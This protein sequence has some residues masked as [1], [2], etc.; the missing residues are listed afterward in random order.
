[1]TDTSGFRYAIEDAPFLLEQRRGEN[2]GSSPERRLRALTVA[3]IAQLERQGNVC[4]DWSR[5]LVALDFDPAPVVYNCFLDDVVL[6][7]F[8]RSAEQR[9]EIPPGVFGSTLRDVVVEDNASIHRCPL[10]SGY[11][12]ATGAVVFDSTLTFDGPSTQGNGTEIAAGIESGGREIALLADLDLPWAT[13]IL[14]NPADSALREAYERYTAAYLAACNR[15]SGY[16]GRGAVVRHCTRIENSWIG[17][18]AQLRGVQLLRESSVHCSAE[19]P[20]VLGDGVIVEYSIVQHGARVESGAAVQ[21]ALIMEYAAVEHHAKVDQSIIGPNSSIGEGEVNASLIGPFVGAHH[22]SLLIAACWPEGRGTIGYG[23]NVGSN[24]TSR[25]P[26]QELWPGEGMFFGLS[27][28]IKMPANFRDAPY[29]VIAAGVTTLPQRLRFPF[30]LI[31]E[32]GEQLSGVSPAFN[33]L[34]PAWGLSSNL[35]GLLRNETKFRSRDRARR[36]RF[37]FS[38]FRDD[39]LRLMEDSVR[40]LEAVPEVRDYYLPGDLDGIGKNYVLESDRK[41]AVETYRFFLRYTDALARMD[42]LH[43]RLVAEN[44]TPTA[45]DSA[46]AE[47]L[48]E[49]ARMIEAV[50]AG[51]VGSRAKDFERGVRIIDDYAATHPA[52]D[53]DALIRDSAAWV[54]ET[55]DRIATLQQRIGVIP[56][57]DVPGDPDTSG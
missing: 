1:M 42:D 51:V 50:H 26:D 2:Q 46:A 10:V 28:A 7:V 38:V 21:Q 25:A 48:G 55:Q 35:Y 16:V 15:N 31:L 52:L 49:L 32:A 37:D 9:C 34:I 30:S 43:R 44:G 57:S 39:I 17:D 36:H 12:I 4:T 13:R 56:G 33:R 19:E 27:C 5:V 24:H 53:N 47:T 40:R 20:A 41:E 3:E 23:A 6:G 29:S 54:A 8:T 22:Q 11:G 45:G 18:G 14:E